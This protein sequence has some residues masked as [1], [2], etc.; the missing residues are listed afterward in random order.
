MDKA[1]VVAA[2]N[3]A[4][5][6]RLVKDID[7]LTRPSIRLRTTPIDEATLPVGA[8]KLGGLPDLPPGM[9]WPAWQGLPQSLHYSG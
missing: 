7:R 6:T 8:S 4:G 9:T 2:L 5:L 3:A 1:A